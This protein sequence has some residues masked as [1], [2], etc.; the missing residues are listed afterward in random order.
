[1]RQPDP[2]PSHGPAPALR[3]SHAERQLA[4]DILRIAAGDGRLTAAELDQ[5][6][7]AALTAR[8][9]GELAALTADLPD[10]RMLRAISRAR[11]D[12]DP[13]S[14]WALLRSLTM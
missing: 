5:R 9:I 10:G 3:A 1:M 6:L 8:S 14:R 13:G 11:A 12:E 7:D 2:R 4:V